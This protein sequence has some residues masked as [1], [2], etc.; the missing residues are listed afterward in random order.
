MVY[1]AV[2]K[3]DSLAGLIRSAGFRATKPRLLLLSYL[4]KTKRP[5]TI[6]E[7]A[8]ALKK[9]IDQVTVYRI[10]DA[11]KNTGLVRELDLKQGRPL[12]EIADEHDHHHV[13]CLGCN[14]VEDFEGCESEKLAKDAL[15]QTPSFGKITTHS[16]EFFGFCKAC[17]KNNVATV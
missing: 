6:L 13:V 15:M 11:F 9:D 1:S 3:K 14:R 4:Q 10:I 2:M 7:I 17:I 5:Q 12:Y 8:D 16:F